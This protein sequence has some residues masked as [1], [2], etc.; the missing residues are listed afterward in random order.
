MT[1]S[2]L[3]EPV[4]FGQTLKLSCVAKN[5][6]IYDLNGVTWYKQSKNSRIILVNNKQSFFKAKYQDK[7]GEED[8]ERVL[9]ILKINSSDFNANYSCE[10]GLYEAWVYL[11][12][13][14]TDVACKYSQDAA[15]SRLSM[16]RY[17][18]TNV[19]QL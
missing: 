19:F 11:S 18:V 8:F 9:K 14:S 2:L 7:H 12:L 1:L 3:E 15:L 17:Y 5:K 16:S 13:N 4:Q 10:F 6:T